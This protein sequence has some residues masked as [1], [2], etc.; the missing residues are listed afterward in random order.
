MRYPLTALPLLHAHVTRPPPPPTPREARSL[1]RNTPTTTA[2]LIHDEDSGDLTYPHLSL[3]P[4]APR[5]PAHYHSLPTLTRALRHL[6]SNFPGSFLCLT[7]RYDPVLLSD[8]PTLTVVIPLGSTSITPSLSDSFLHDNRDYPHPSA[9]PP[10]ISFGPFHLSLNLLYPRTTDDIYTLLWIG[11]PCPPT[12]ESKGPDSDDR[13]IW[14]TTPNHQT[15]YPHPHVSNCTLCMGDALNP[16]RSAFHSCDLLTIC[17]MV[18]AV[19]SNYN[20]DSPYRPLH[21]FLP[22]T[23]YG[24]PSCVESNA[25]SDHTR[26]CCSCGDPLSD[27]DALW[28][29]GDA[30][31]YCESC[32]SS[33]YTYCKRCETDVRC[34]DCSNVIID[35]RGRTRTWCRSCVEDNTITCASCNELISDR[36]SIH[37]DHD[38]EYYCPRCY[39][40]L[41]PADRGL[42]PDCLSPTSDCTCEDEEEEEPTEEHVEE[43]TTTPDP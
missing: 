2:H 1:L 30:G 18:L 12:Y 34:D 7:T 36:I 13:W 41:S 35:S 21:A 42:C 20:P 32:Y 4:P 37:N 5:D 3:L 43:P 16:I 11:A 31:P 24:L 39:N 14:T 23:A 10:P 33:I 26:T 17:D 25:P 28:G 38:E 6:S 27:G 15:D 19:L 40:D 22:P 29:P 9:A 8:Q